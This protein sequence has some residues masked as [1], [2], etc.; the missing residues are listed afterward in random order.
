MRQA[1]KPK[2]NIRA[3][4]SDSIHRLRDESE[5]E[6]EDDNFEL[7]ARVRT[8]LPQAREA[9]EKA[10]AEI[11]EQERES[12]SYEGP[13][14]ATNIHNFLDGLESTAS[15]DI[16]GLGDL[17]VLKKIFL[18]YREELAQH[19]VEV[20]ELTEKRDTYKLLS[21]KLQAK[22]EAARKEHVEW[23]KQAHVDTIQAKV[24]E[25]K[26]NMDLITLE[27]EAVQAQLASAE[28]QLRATK[29]KTLVQA[30]KIEEL[31]SEL[32]S[33][34]SGQE[35]LA[36]ELEAAKY[37]SMVEHVRWQSRREA[38][39]GVHA[40]SFDILAEI[41]NAKVEEARARKLDFPKEDSESLT[42]FEGRE[43]L[44]DEDAA[45][46]EDQTT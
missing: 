1:R 22:L 18:R 21:E 36:K 42:E 38:L 19:E 17:L 44:E 7:V 29:E 40:Q 27:K 15:E 13:Q 28:A 41:E 45:L 12:H 10:L 46:D 4:P 16:T 43:D 25:F 39:K 35:S 2:E 6:E 30:K 5:Q 34:I 33:T 8:A 31:Q 32:N 20:R 11:S 26:K 24:E 9:V 23:A 37:K 3:L 14:G